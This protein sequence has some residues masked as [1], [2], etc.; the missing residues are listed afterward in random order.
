MEYERGVRFKLE[1]KDLSHRGLYLVVDR[2][3]LEG[4]HLS[5]DNLAKMVS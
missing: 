1:I 3:I 5:C 2:R 4:S